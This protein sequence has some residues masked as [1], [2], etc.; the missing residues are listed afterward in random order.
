MFLNLT[1]RYSAPYPA[2]Y[3]LD[4]FR[5]YRAMG[6]RADKFFQMELK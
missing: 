6:K 3:M 5:F 4:K 1:R 2:V